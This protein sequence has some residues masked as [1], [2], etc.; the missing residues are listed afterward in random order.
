V[1]DER[2]VAEIQLVDQPHRIVDV[3]RSE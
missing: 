2:D 3:I 1:R